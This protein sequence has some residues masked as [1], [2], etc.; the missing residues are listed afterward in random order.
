MKNESS[1]ADSDDL[2]RVIA[3]MLANAA[4]ETFSLNEAAEYLRISPDSVKYYCKRQRELSHAN[5]GGVLVF[6]KRDLDEFLE[7]KLKRGFV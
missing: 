6:R 7:K 1:G 2:A 3:Q 4:K 5:L